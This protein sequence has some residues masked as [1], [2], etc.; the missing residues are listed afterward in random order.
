MLPGH[1]IHPAVTTEVAAE[2]LSAVG[3]AAEQTLLVIDDDQVVHTRTDADLDGVVDRV[4]HARSPEEGIRLAMDALP[5][6]ILLDIHLPTMSGLQVCRHLKE[7]AATR[8]IPVVFLTVAKG[9]KQVARALDCGGTD[10]ITKPF[11]GVELQARVRAAL[12]TKQLIDLLKEQARIDA[13]TGLGNRAALDD[14]LSAAVAAHERT[15]QGFALLM[16][17]LDRFKDVNDEYGHRVGDEVLRR[18][19]AAIRS[20]CRPYDIACRYGGDEF[21]IVLHQTGEKDAERVGQRVLASIRSLAVPTGDGV[22]RVTCSGGLA[23]VPEKGSSADPAEL[24]RA[25]DRALYQ[26]KEE[27]RN[28]LSVAAVDEAASPA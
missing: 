27:G 1:P 23:R 5:S 14:G 25:A 8:E 28:R 15:G 3:G 13:L 24:L 20:S 2:G 10:Y 22:L 26:A 12:R 17:D 7:C 11:E 19:G 18:V 6:V 16:L 9:T 4:L 21:A